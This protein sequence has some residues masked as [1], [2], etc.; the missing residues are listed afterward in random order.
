MG[1]SADVC[2]F[3]RAAVCCFVCHL[4][5]LYP[6]VSLDPVPMYIMGVPGAVVDGP[7]DFDHNF[8]GA[9]L[10][11]SLGDFHGVFAVAVQM[12]L[13]ALRRGSMA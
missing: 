2:S 13:A 7:D 4:V 5:S 10:P 3:R 12:E 11:E 6:G 9:G 1:V 8:V